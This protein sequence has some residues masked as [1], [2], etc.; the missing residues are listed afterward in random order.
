MRAI[1]EEITSFI[2]PMTSDLTK[3]KILY[4]IEYYVENRLLDPIEYIALMFIHEKCIEDET[5]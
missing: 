4:S 3:G 5:I 1:K 2:L